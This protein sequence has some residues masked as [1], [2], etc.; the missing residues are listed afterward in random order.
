MAL[1]LLY[2]SWRFQHSSHVRV[3]CVL[4]QAH[5]DC[6]LGLTSSNWSS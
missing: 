5:N 6:S 4:I 1:P 2:F 3:G